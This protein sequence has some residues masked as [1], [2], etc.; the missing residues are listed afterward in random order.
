[1]LIVRK[2]QVKMREREREREKDRHKE[3]ERESATSQIDSFVL[4]SAL[5][6]F[7]VVR[8]PVSIV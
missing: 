5:S 3:C 8:F 7:Q 1:M 6:V 2:K 4:F